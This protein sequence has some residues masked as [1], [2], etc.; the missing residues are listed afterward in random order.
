MYIGFHVKCP[1]VLSDFNGTWI[2]WTEFQKILKYKFLW[3]SVRWEPSC[4]MRAG[5]RRGRQAGRHDES[6]SRF[7][8]FCKGA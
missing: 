5:G 2:F 4:S 1:L 3:K 7:S 6:N 8:Q